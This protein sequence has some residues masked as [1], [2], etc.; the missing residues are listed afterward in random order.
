MASTL[1]PTDITPSKKVCLFATS[2][3]RSYVHTDVFKAASEIENFT[4]DSTPS[5]DAEPEIPLTED[6]VE[7]AKPLVGLPDLTKEQDAVE[8]AKHSVAP[9][10][11]G[12][13]VNE[14]LLQE[15]PNRF[16]LFPIRY[17]EVCHHACVLRVGRVNTYSFGRHI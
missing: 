15:N 14:P 3:V 10:L 13:E 5:K 9:T 11:K 2:F 6:G 12:E 8:E 17:H 1:L 4:L 16:V 7:K